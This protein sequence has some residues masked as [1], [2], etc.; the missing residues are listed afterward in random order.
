MSRKRIVRE[1]FPS[2]ITNLFL[3]LAFFWWIAR[4]MNGGAEAEVHE[5]FA[6][7][8]TC[9]TTKA[10]CSLKF[11]F[12]Y[13]T[14]LCHVC[15]LKYFIFIFPLLCLA[16]DVIQ[17]LINYVVILTVTS[18]THKAPRNKQLINGFWRWW[19][20]FKRFDISRVLYSDYSVWHMASV[21]LFSI[22][23]FFYP[24]KDSLLRVWR[25]QETRQVG[26]THERIKECSWCLI[27]SF[28][29][30]LKLMCALM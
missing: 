21:N 16:P 22:L 19:W 28:D 7:S 24:F 4:H 17:E 14:H 6:N 9:K 12:Q 13:C 11:T 23:L 20:T 15:M 30:Y 26:R 1:N 8:S 2:T 3:R 29:K 10:C 5:L 25:V 18:S 27:N